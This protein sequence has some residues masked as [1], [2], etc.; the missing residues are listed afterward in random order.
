MA[1]TDKKTE[2]KATAAVPK[3]KESKKEAKGAT[4]KTAAADKVSLTS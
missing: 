2:K 1:K 3:V 4:S